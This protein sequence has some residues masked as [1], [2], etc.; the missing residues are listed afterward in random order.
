MDIVRRSMD[1]SQHVFN[2]TY[3][4]KFIEAE[5][6]ISIIRLDHCKT[7]ITVFTKDIIQRLTKH[8]VLSVTRIKDNQ[9]H[10]NLLQL[11]GDLYISCKTYIS[12]EVFNKIN[13]QQNFW[14][15]RNASNRLMLF[16][17][18]SP[19]QNSLEC[20]GHLK[21]PIC[22]SVLEGDDV[23]PL[24]GALNSLKLNGRNTKKELRLDD[25]GDC[26]ETPSI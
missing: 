3:S 16:E 5:H 1:L 25:N 13:R 21:M 19:T 26:L 8:R 11:A 6:T 10:K 24:E 15:G 23:I 4:K 17:E 18:S 20:I 9:G 7:F 14:F 12:D 2:V 22:R